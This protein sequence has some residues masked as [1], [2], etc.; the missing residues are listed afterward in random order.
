MVDWIPYMILQFTKKILI[1]RI[2]EW[3]I[4]CTSRKDEYYNF[5]YFTYAQSSNS[6]L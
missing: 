5:E 2:Y 4:H 6:P 3:G 1:D